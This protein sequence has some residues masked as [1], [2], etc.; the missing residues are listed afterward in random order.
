MN[1]IRRARAVAAATVTAAVLAAAT[2]ACSAGA[3]KGNVRPVP[4]SACL[5]L[6]RCRGHD[7]TVACEYPPDSC[8]PQQPSLTRDVIR[9]GVR[10]LPPG[11]AS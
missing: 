9:S 5:S 10:P 4:P 6:I 11:K 8:R 1:R 7:I 2:A 3:A